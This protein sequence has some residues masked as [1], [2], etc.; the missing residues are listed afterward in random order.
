MFNMIKILL[1]MSV[2]LFGSGFNLP[3]K[4]QTFLKPNEAFVVT[5]VKQD[6]I[7]KTTIKLGDKI[8]IYDESLHFMITKPK[9][10]EITDLK[11]PTPHV[12]DE[13]KVH[14]GT[15]IIDIPI[16][17]IE[18]QVSGK[19]TLSVEMEGCSI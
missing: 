13:D 12:V 8:H 18:S 17:T 16:D 7:I 1:L 4:K 2:M 6:N 11:L 15:I 19:Y 10:F 14:S 3:H 9:K 5:A